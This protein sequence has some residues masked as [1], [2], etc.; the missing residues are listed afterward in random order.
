VAAPLAGKALHRAADARQDRHNRL[1]RAAPD[2]PT[3]RISR[4]ARWRM[5]PATLDPAGDAG[6]D[7]EDDD[8]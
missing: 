3:P 2:A 5:C 1:V 7:G 4:R 6:P 8:A